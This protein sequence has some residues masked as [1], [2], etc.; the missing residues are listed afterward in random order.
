LMTQAI[1]LFNRGHDTT[2]GLFE[3]LKLRL[4]Q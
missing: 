3:A 1:T 4:L 2:E